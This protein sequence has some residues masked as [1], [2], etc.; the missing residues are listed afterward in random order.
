MLAAGCGGSAAE[1]HSCGATDKRFI[2]T[3]DLNI[4]ALGLWAAGYQRGE[5]EPDEVAEEAFAAAARVEDARPQ[6]ASLRQAQRLLAPMFSEY[7]HAVALYA[8]GKSA[9]ERMHRAYGLANFA[10]EVLVE[11]QPELAS[12][13]CDVAPLL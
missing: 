11:A 3:A 4:T 13:G 8:D 9:G 2:Q 5:I 7:G 12:R 6:D 10:R 1:A